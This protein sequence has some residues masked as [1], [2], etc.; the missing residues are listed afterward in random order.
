MRQRVMIAIALANQPDVIVADEPTTALDVTIQAQIL[1]LLG[2]LNRDL[3]TAIVLITHNLGV[4]A[5]SC[6]RVAVMYGGR[7]VEQAGGRG[8]VRATAAPLHAGAAG[9]DAAPGGGPRRPAGPDRGPATGPRRPDPGLRL[10]AALRRGR[11]A[12]PSR[13]ATHVRGARVGPGS[14][15]SPGSDGVL[16]PAPPPPASATASSAPTGREPLLT[17][18]DAGEDLPGQAPQ[19]P[20]APRPTP[21]SAPSTAS[22]SPSRPGETRRVWWGSPAAAS[23]PWPGR[24]SGSTRR[25]SGTDHLRG[26]RRRRAGRRGAA[27]VPQPGPAGLPGPDVVAQ[28]AA[29]RR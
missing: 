7:I 14:A 3:G 6:Q 12:L 9:R 21:R 10:R 16:P 27:Q 4:V 20:A 28:P 18:E 8:A 19:R 15:G 22:T 24:S 5:R 1:E 23:P 11:G 26:S 25:P 17:V 29:D 2:E 13:A